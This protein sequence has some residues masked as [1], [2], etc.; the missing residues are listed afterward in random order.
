M[1]TSYK[2]VS[3]FSRA[4]NEHLE[5]RKGVLSYSSFM[6]GA[7]TLLLLTAMSACM[8]PDI[9]LDD[10]KCDS[11]ARCVEGYVCDPATRRCVADNECTCVEG[12]PVE[13][14]G[15]FYLVT[16]SA[17]T[18]VGPCPGGDTPVVLHTGPPNGD[19]GC[20]DCAC[21]EA[22]GRCSPAP[23]L[24]GENDCSNTDIVQAPLDQCTQFLA[25]T[26]ECRLDGGDGTY[27]GRCAPQ[28][29][30]EAALPGWKTDLTLC[31]LPVDPRCGAGHCENPALQAQIC[32]RQAGDAVCPAPWTERTIAYAGVEDTRA[33]TECSCT[34]AIAG[35]GPGFYGLYGG[36]ELCLNNDPIVTIDSTSCSG[37]IMGVEYVQGFGDDTPE[38]PHCDAEGGV[39][40]GEFV[41]QNAVTLCCLPA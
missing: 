16:T 10:A 33:C 28:Q 18:E 17:G 39:L 25:E 13:W 12:V 2:E 9:T 26:I 3:C 11:A 29:L 8:V 7:R 23:L 37:P 35:C 1:T 31:E 34:A 14:Q 19:A 36:N 20:F 30:G 6:N 41:P 32:M 27:E 24:C 4:R 38:D 22:D 5:T 40:E 15:P 21:G